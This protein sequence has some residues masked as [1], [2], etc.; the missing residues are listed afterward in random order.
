MIGSKNTNAGG[1]SR[2]LSAVLPEL[3][4]YIQG[5]RLFKCKRCEEDLVID[6]FFNKSNL[7]KRELTKRIDT[8]E[9]IKEILFNYKNGRK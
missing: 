5:K 6:I 7:D 9:K 4:D 8:K 3:E 2:K 1:F